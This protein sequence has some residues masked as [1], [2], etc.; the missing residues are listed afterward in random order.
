MILK[1]EL[2]GENL[3][4]QKLNTRS[5]NRLNKASWKGLLISGVAVSLWFICVG[6]LLL[7]AVAVT[8]GY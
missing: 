3:P 7:K 1:I 8:Y 6:L 2:F 4:K 5:V